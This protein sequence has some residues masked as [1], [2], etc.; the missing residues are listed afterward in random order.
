MP[1]SAAI[2]FLGGG[3]GDPPASDLRA[4]IGDLLPLGSGR[5]VLSVPQHRE[6]MRTGYGSEPIIAEAA[7]R[8]MLKEDDL[9]KDASYW[10]RVINSTLASGTFN[11]GPNGELAMRLLLTC[12]YD[13]AVKM[14]NAPCDPIIQ[15]DRPIMLITFLIALLG[16][17]NADKVLDSVP[18]NQHHLPFEDRLSLRERFKDAKVRF[19]HFMRAGSPEV[20]KDQS[21]WPALVRGFAYQCCDGQKDI[22]II[23]PILLNGNGK[24]DASNVSALAF[25]IKNTIHAANPYVDIAS[26][27]QDGINLFS[28]EDGRPYIAVTANLGV[29]KSEVIPAP[30]GQ[31][32]SNRI[33][34]HAR[35]AFTVNG[36]NTSSYPCI[37][38]VSPWNILLNK[39]KLL[40]E[41]PHGGDRLMCV[42]R[43][44][45]LVPEIHSEWAVPNKQGD[46]V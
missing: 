42:R 35:Y 32:D 4:P 36:C 31:R 29:T 37:T 24:L 20:V 3:G 44:C 1:P 8:I 11:K 15:C 10:A 41:H 45:D 22:D 30:S 19:T 17:S 23:I 40:D 33:V 28:K 7:A 38:D 6:Y 13:R 12:A 34:N 16:S 25:Q 9:P 21:M 26:T 39:G 14:E 46:A 43:M 2:P 18:S 5:L 27:R